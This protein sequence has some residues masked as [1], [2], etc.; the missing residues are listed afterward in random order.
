MYT[1]YHVEGNFFKK[2]YCSYH[3]AFYAYKLVLQLLEVFCEI[4]GSKPSIC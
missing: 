1:K 3:L 2:G 4:C